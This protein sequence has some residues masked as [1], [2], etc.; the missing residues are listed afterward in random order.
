MLTT[1]NVVML[2]GGLTKD[3]EVFEQ[4]GVVHLSLAIDSSGSE[5]GVSNASGYFDVKVWMTPS[6]FSPQ[7]TAD[8]VRSLLTDNK[9]V[10]GA[11]VGI[12][13][14][15]VQERWKDKENRSMART[16][17]VAE[18][19]DAYVSGFKSNSNGA[20]AESASISSDQPESS[21]NLVSVIDEF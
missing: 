4:A 13:G 15:L 2:S 10:K 17:V 21:N 6:K 12:V 20:S 8:N 14:R 5:K 11:R 7:A 1:K 19:I 18:S 9:L 16:V 3:A